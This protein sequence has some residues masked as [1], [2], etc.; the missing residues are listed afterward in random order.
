MII[1]LFVKTHYFIFTFIF[2]LLLTF[3]CLS[4]SK[5]FTK[6]LNDIFH[7]M[8][9]DENQYYLNEENQTW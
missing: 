3:N 5:T 1:T 4:R 9:L 7:R 6:Y 8:V 2:F